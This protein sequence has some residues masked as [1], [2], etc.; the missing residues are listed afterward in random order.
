MEKINVLLV[1]DELTLAGIVKDTLETMEFSVTI[2]K[3]G[4][5]GLMKFKELH[6]DIVVADVMMPEMS[7]FDMVGTIRKTDMKT[8]VIFLTAKTATD[9]VVE[10]FHIGANDY[11]KKP[12]AIP[13]LVVRIKALLGRISLTQEA[14]EAYNIGEYCFDHIAGV[15]TYTPDGR[16]TRLPGREA[17]ILKMLCQNRNSAVPTR[18]ILLN[19]W[20][21]D[22]YFTSRSLQV[23]VTR[24][25]HHLS[26]DSRIR[27]VNVRGFGYKLL[28]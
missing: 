24:L 22:D 13:E 26:S 28:V 12:F 19:L 15:L 10:G 2:A 20:G 27:I 5:E 21:N 3:D 1:E 7:G 18:D 14:E 16:A 25:R 23:L 8:P 9:D 17:D 4:K 6:P 11:L